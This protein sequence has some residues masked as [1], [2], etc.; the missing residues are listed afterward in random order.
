MYTL[1][2]DICKRSLS[3]LVM[4]CFGCAWPILPCVMLSVCNELFDFY[5]ILDEKASAE[6]CHFCSFP[7]INLSS[8]MAN[9]YRCVMA[10]Q[11]MRKWQKQTKNDFHDTPVHKALFVGGMVQTYF[12]GQPYI[13]GISKVDFYIESPRLL[14]KNP[15]LPLT[16]HF[17]QKTENQI[18]LPF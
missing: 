17:F 8:Q 16:Y 3:I 14:G 12:F 6:S 2:H 4:I 18:L 9:D 5:C 10:L 13:Y 15:H 7:V 1:K 11:I